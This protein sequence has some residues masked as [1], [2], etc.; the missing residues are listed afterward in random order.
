MLNITP[1]RAGSSPR[2]MLNLDLDLDLDLD[3]CLDLD[4]PVK[5]DLAP[6]FFFVAL[7]GGPGPG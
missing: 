4:H 7:V 1:P 5:S 6:G 3:Y 2:T